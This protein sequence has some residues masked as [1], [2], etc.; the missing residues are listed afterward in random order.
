MVFIINTV[1]FLWQ[2]GEEVMGAMDRSLQRDYGVNLE[3]SYNRYITEAWDK[4]QSEVR[5]SY[6]RMSRIF[7]AKIIL[8][9]INQVQGVHQGLKCP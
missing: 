5:V 4:A 7:I 6:F 2:I 1:T 8:L 3:N 9:L